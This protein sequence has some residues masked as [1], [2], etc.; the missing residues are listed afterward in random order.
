MYNYCVLRVLYL[1]K[2]IDKCVD[3]ITI[4]NVNVVK[5]H[6]TEKVA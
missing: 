3:V 4:V 1:F 6:G 5:S 2:S